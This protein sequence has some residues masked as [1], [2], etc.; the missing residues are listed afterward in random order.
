MLL[1]KERGGQREPRKLLGGEGAGGT[2]TAMGS[3]R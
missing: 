3:D 1:E 2:Q